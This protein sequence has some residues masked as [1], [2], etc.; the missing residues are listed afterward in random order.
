MF[1]LSS[2]PG[3]EPISVAS[4][5][6]IF[7]FCPVP[8]LSFPSPEEPLELYFCE[9]EIAPYPQLR[10]NNEGRVVVPVAFGLGYEPSPEALA[11]AE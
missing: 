3:A 9:L 2:V 4:L 7:K 5:F 8:F 10:A 1:L 6:D 11:A